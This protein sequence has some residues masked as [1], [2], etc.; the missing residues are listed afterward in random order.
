MPSVP[1]LSFDLWTTAPD[2]FADALGRALRDT[3]F[4]VVT[5]H[6]IPADTI[7][8]ADR[9]AR[10]LFGLKPDTKRRYS[11]PASGF[12]R[13]YSPLGTETAVGGSKPDLKEFWHVGRPEGVPGLPSNPEV[14]EV[15]EFGAATEALWRELDSFS[16]ELLRAVA[17]HLG[18]GRDGLEGIAR[19]GNSILRLLRYPAHHVA[20]AAGEERAAA[21][22][23]INLITL[24][25]GAEE[26]GLEVLH[27]SG[28]WMPIN[29]EPGAVVV[30]TG[31][32]LERVTAG[33]LPSTTHR[34]VNP[35]G[36]AAGRDRYS[37]PFFLHP[38]NDA[39][40]R[41]L[42]TCVAEG[43][44]ARPPITAGA[45]LEERLAQIGLRKAS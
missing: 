26:A 32:M 31:D 4:A 30:N 22:E 25:L 23:D 14:A 41:A 19:G 38:R 10:A 44:R 40:L 43:G 29:P 36:E 15:P 16:G 13:G 3:G 18:L 1:T 37:M 33:V 8:A 34:V 42:P 17:V 28:E 24:L 35:S 2:A 7:A 11:D 20:P 45:Y 27:R 12:Q 5:D 21:H 9:A 39:V 6:T